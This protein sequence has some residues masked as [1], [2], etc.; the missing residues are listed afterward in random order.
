MTPTT[1]RVHLRS[2]AALQPQKAVDMS[3]LRSPMA[4]GKGGLWMPALAITDRRVCACTDP[5]MLSFALAVLSTTFAASPDKNTTLGGVPCGTGQCPPNTFCC[6]D[7]EHCCENGY[8]CDL[9]HGQ[10]VKQT[11]VV[12]LPSFETK[13][14]IKATGPQ[15]DWF[16]KCP[17]NN[18]CCFNSAG[19]AVNCCPNGKTCDINRGTCDSSATVS[20]PALP[21]V[22]A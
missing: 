14:V 1:P 20:T 17:D 15:C 8:K 6:N 9:E 18:H 22:A 5:K 11:P 10:C 16:R 12:K 2:R 7:L 21:F 13:P 19:A 3:G 4:V